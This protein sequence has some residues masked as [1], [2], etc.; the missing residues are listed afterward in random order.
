M[1][2]IFS[3]TR[4]PKAAQHKPEQCA[5]LDALLRQYRAGIDAI[6]YSTREA[7]IKAEWLIYLSLLRVQGIATNAASERR[8]Q[9]KRLARHIGHTLTIDDARKA[10]GELDVLLVELITADLEAMQ[11]PGPPRKKRYP[12]QTKP[13][14]FRLR[15]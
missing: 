11:K 7:V 13:A 2:L 5:A 10:Y 8:L 4:K 14:K 1:G 6:S 9:V 15:L 3:T 12:F